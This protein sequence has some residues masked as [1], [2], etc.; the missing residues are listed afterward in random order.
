LSLAL[1]LGMLSADAG[2]AMAAAALGQGSAL[3]TLH[4]SRQQE[5]QA[6]ADAL[7]ATVA[8][9]G[10]AGGVTRL[11][12]RLG[13]LSGDGTPALKLLRTHPL[14]AARQAAVRAQAQQAGW[15]VEG[16]S[17]RLPEALRWP[18]SADQRTPP[19]AAKTPSAGG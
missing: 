10:H 13:Q 6:D 16:A 12:E 17:P 7:R 2:A 9:Y 4:H 8:L 1:L 15:A 19:A 11:F 18:A 3:L 5:T 14:T